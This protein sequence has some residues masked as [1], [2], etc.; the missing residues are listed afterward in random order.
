MKPPFARI[1]YTV[2]PTL[3]KRLKAMAALGTLLAELPAELKKYNPDEP[4]V[5]A[6]S[7]QGTVWTQTPEAEV[8]KASPDDPKHPG[9]PPGTPD[10][11]GGKFRPKDGDESA[12]QGSHAPAS[13]RRIALSI[14]EECEAQ[15]QKDLIECRLAGSPACYAQAMLRYS[16]CLRGLPVPP[17]NY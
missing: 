9:W 4:G 1:Q 6:G 2:P 3:E 14:E 17:L 8:L 15:Y 10:G 11:K 5:P 16:N 13:G 7:P 12:A